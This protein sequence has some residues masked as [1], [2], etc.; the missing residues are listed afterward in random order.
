MKPQS[1]RVSWNAANTSAKSWLKTRLEER[2]FSFSEKEPLRGLE[3][4]LKRLQCIF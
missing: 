3:G 2:R 1:D 4:K